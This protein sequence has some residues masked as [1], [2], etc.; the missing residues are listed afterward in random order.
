MQIG[1]AAAHPLL[2]DQ[3]SFTYPETN[4]P[5]LNNVSLAI[6]PGERVLIMGSSGSGKSTLGLTLNGIVPRITGGHYSG[7]VRI[8]DRDPLRTSLSTI[9]SLVGLVFQDP[10]SQLCTITT[11]D[12]IAFGPQNLLVPREEIVR[13][14]AE[15]VEFVGL[16][17]RLHEWVFN[18]SGGQK[19]RVA[20]ASALVMHPSVLVMDE[21]TANLDPSGRS[22]VLRVMKEILSRTGM[23]SIIVEHHP[24]ELLSVSERLVIMKEGT[25]LH[26]GPPR[27]V[28]ARS[29]HQIKE[30]GIRL[31]A[32]VSFWHGLMRLD[33]PVPLKKSEIDFDR[34]AGP[35]LTDS[36]PV[37]FDRS[38]RPATPAL[39]VEKVTFSYREQINV[40]NDVSFQLGKGEIVAML[41][42]NGSGKSTLASLLV[43]MNR[44]KLG[45]ILLDGKNTVTLPVRELAKYIGYVFQYPEHQFI[46][47]SVL[48]E[49]A[50][51]IRRMEP[52]SRD[53]LA[54][55]REELERFDL[56]Q[57]ADRHPFKLSQ[58]QKRR[59]SIAAMAV[60]RPKILVLDEPTFGQD[61]AHTDQ[62]A[63]VIRELSADRIGVLLITHDLCLMAELADR[64]I[65]LS[66]GS[67]AFDGD[68]HALLEILHTRPRWQ[69]EQLE[70]Y[71]LWRALSLRIPDLQFNPDPEQLARACLNRTGKR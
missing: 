32:A 69:L 19:Q 12:E 33:L 66:G 45:R 25:V 57:F 8:G 55:A 1:P 47:D 35:I 18:L 64:A 2:W 48:E 67:I 38:N 9:A 56:A 49:V 34:I 16:A 31:P 68:T 26:S 61:Q 40:L 21:P 52:N 36:A 10:D 59:L 28:L 37:A 5:A 46:T 42:A 60:Y 44:P 22:E 15:T 7:K 20:I 11:R 30:I 71:E 58:G 70:E 24:G 63:A 14:L 27:T 50:I 13:R 62:L 53:V 6:E 3:F 4:S 41:G 43:G 65:V 51:S 29:A 23:T 39:I 54:Q 17:D